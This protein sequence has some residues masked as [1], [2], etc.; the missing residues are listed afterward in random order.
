MAE[1]G[2]GSAT[3]LRLAILHEGLSP[4]S[5]AQ[6]PEESRRY[7][8]LQPPAMSIA[9]AGGKASCCLDLPTGRTPD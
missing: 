6:V 7:A 2:S 4:G 5:L 3:A 1:A 9:S 8:G